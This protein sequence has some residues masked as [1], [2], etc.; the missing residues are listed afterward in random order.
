MIQTKMIRKKLPTKVYFASIEDSSFARYWLQKLESYPPSI[1]KHCFKFFKEDDQ[2]KRLLG[3][4]LLEQHLIENNISDPLF[5]EIKREGFFKPTFIKLPQFHFNLSYSGEIAVCAFSQD[6]IG[7]DIEKVNPDV[8]LD[9]YKSV[10]SNEVWENIISSVDPKVSFFTHWTQMEAVM[11]A[12]GH[13]IT[14]PIDQII[15]GNKNISVNGVKRD[16]V[17]VPTVKE[18]ITHVVGSNLDE[19]NIQRKYFEI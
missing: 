10:F 4:W 14:G 17:F 2:K 13:G 8:N 1:I 9:H 18:Y 5:H 19:I 3:Y 7:V 12:D 15:Y 16:L 6:S 11:K